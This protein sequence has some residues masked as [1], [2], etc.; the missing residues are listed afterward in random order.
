MT[1][2]R[3]TPWQC[4]PTRAGLGIWKAPGIMA[5][6]ERRETAGC[7][8]FSTQS[9][10]QWRYL[11]HIVQSY[12]RI[13]CYRPYTVF[14]SESIHVCYVVPSPKYVYNF[15]TMV[16]CISSYDSC[17]IC[18]FETKGWVLVMSWL[19]VAG[20]AWATCK[21]QYVYAQQ[22]LQTKQEYVLPEIL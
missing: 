18:F 13:M 1:C 10:L 2:G 9:W 12:S 22:T 20:R 11:D 19:H 5:V 16:P 14:T 21:K 3:G 4:P 17:G 6:A 15:R 8:N 7:D